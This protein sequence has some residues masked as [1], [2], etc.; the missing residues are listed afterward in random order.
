MKWKKKWN[1]WNKDWKAQYPILPTPEDKIWIFIRGIGDKKARRDRSNI[2]KF[3]IHYRAKINGVWMNVIRC[4]NVHTKRPHLHNYYL[5]DD[6]LLREDIPIDRDNPTQ[7]YKEWLRKIGTGC[8]L[9]RALLVKALEN[10]KK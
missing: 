6:K 1:Y 10:K 4:D 9:Y 7:I 8:R 5:L 3:S 2:T